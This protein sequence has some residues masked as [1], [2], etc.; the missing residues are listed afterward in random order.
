MKVLLTGSTG[1]IGR[2]LKQKLLQD[3]NI[4]LRLLVRNKKSITPNLE[5]SVEIC[6]GNSFDV[7]SLKKAL[8][9]VEVAFYL[10]HSL[11][12][13]DY[14]NL[15]K[16]SA[17]NFLDAAIFCGVKKIIYLGGLGVKNSD[18]SQHLLSRLETGEILSSSDKIQTIWIRAGVIIGSGSASFEIIRNLTEKLPIMTTPKW[19]NTKTQPIAVFD[20]LNYLYSSIYLEEKGNITIDVGAEQLTYKDMM[21]QTATALGLKRY[22]IPLPFLSITL[23]S[24]WLNLFTPVSYGVAKALIE[25]LKSEATIQNNNAI[26]YFPNIKPISYINSVKKAVDE[27]RNNQVVCRWSDRFG[28]VWDKD[29]TEEVAHA[30]YVDRRVEDISNLSHEKVYKSFISIGGEFGWFDYDFL[31]KTRGVIDKMIGGVGLKRG[32]RDQLN[33]R[34]G[35]SLDFWKVIDVQE[36]KRLLLLA[37][38]KLPGN[39]WLEFKIDDNKL[40]QSAYFYPKGLLGRLY[41]YIL[42]PVRERLKFRRA[43]KIPCQ[44]PIV[45]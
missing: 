23:S 30:I 39:A 11:N 4:I 27:I 10:I 5:R 22:I 21:L 17:Q 42:V 7:E 36:N 31:W 19:V 8:K 38:M 3:E 32:R 34:I 20:V 35:D 9:D 12:R 13:K 2:R 41:W 37:Q 18:T 43:F 24:Y 25:G 16:T 45:T 33:L 40:I 6:E 15:D 44:S 1:Y 26:K 29:Y 28:R 14:K